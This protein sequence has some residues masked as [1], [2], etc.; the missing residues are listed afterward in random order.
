[1]RPPARRGS[2]RVDVFLDHRELRAF[3]GVVHGRRPNG[4]CGVPFPRSL[5]HFGWH[6]RSRT[7][8]DRSPHFRMACRTGLRPPA[9]AGI[10]SLG[11]EPQRRERSHEEARPALTS[12]D[13]HASY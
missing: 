4:G 3:G 13:P 11:L 9:G 8:E 1:M 7:E 2:P 6:S 12:T 5:L 10:T